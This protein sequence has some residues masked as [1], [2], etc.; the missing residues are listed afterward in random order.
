MGGNATEL[1]ID[2][3]DQLFLRRIV[4]PAHFGDERRHVG[5]GFS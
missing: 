2:E 1:R 3:C 5:L 4:P